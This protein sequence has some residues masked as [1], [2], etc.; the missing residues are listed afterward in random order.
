MLILYG[1]ADLARL[2]F[3]N[4]TIDV[5]LNILSPANYGEFYRILRMME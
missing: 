1:V 5:V 2:P 4:R 3:Q